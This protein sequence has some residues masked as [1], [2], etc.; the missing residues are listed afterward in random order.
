MLSNPITEYVITVLPQ[1]AGFQPVHALLG[2]VLFQKCHNS[3]RNSNRSAPTAFRGNKSEDSRL[4]GDI[5]KLLIYQNRALFQIYAVPG[6]ST[7]LPSPKTGKQHGQIDRL[8]L[9]SLNRFDKCRH[10]LAVQGFDFFTFNPWQLTRIRRIEA[11][12]TD[13]HR[14]LQRFMKYTVNI[15]HSLCG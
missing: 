2:F 5:L 10:C 11:Q 6:Q 1:G 14:L 3:S 9:M 15:L 8:K 13:L 4:S 7:R 12:V